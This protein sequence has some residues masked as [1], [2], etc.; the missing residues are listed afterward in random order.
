MKTKGCFADKRNRNDTEV[1]ELCQ[2]P[3]F[4][5]SESSPRGAD[6]ARGTLRWSRDLSE[7][8]CFRTAHL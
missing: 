6:C 1:Q 5:H 7:Q 3:E 4:Q 8:R 2:S